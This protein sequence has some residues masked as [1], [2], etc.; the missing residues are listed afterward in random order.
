MLYNISFAHAPY[1]TI[2]IAMTGTEKC[3]ST[4]YHEQSDTK[5]NITRYIL[6]FYRQESMYIDENN[7]SSNLLLF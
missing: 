1:L 6:I 5:N 7:P 4:P 2:V 3:V